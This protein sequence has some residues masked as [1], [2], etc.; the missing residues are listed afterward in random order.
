MKSPSMN[1][2]AQLELADSFLKLKDEL[3]SERQ[4][5][6]RIAEYCLSRG[7]AD[8]A[9]R[10]EILEKINAQYEEKLKTNKLTEL[11][12]AR[13]V[14]L[15]E[16]EARG[17]LEQDGE[18]REFRIIGAVDLNNLQ[19]SLF[20]KLGDNVEFWV[21]APEEEQDRFDEFG[22]VVPEKWADYQIPL[23]AEQVYQASAPAEQGEVVAPL[24]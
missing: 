19:K 15:A 12:K 14:A 13:M 5:Y 4:T 22:C 20:S 24:R 2:S 3:D 1:L 17:G 9:R 10:W 21:F 6:A 8:E 7:L 11:N 23:D 18:P 16:I